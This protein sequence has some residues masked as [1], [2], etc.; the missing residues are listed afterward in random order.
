LF[1]CLPGILGRLFYT[2]LRPLLGADEVDGGFMVASLC[3]I[4]GEGDGLVLC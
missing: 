4:H 2:Y 1:D 3:Y